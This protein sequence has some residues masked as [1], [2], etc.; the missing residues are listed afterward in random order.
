MSH[1]CVFTI[2]EELVFAITVEVNFFFGGLPSVDELSDSSGEEGDYVGARQSLRSARR[3]TQSASADTDRFDSDSD[4]KHLIS[5]T[6]SAATAAQ[7]FSTDK[8][9]S[10]DEDEGQPPLSSSSQAAMSMRACG[11]RVS[12]VLTKV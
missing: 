8:D 7:R 6:V 1:R 4:D 11:C 5:L 9:G 12:H 3:S 10:N 2:N